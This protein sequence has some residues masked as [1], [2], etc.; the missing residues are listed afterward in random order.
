MLREEFVALTTMYSKQFIAQLSLQV[1]LSAW[2]GD[3]GNVC[4][5]IDL[6]SQGKGGLT[7]AQ[8]DL[9]TKNA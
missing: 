5:S 9:S 4:A 3:S 7:T 8:I 6:A 2:E 1:R